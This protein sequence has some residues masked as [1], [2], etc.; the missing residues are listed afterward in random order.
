[1]RKEYTK[2][3]K[4]TPQISVEIEKLAESGMSAKEVSVRLNLDYLSTRTAFAILGIP[5]KCG[6]H[7]GSSYLPTEA[8]LLKKIESL[9]KRIE[10]LHLYYSGK[11]FDEIGKLYGTSRQYIQQ[12][13]KSGKES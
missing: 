4:I 7:G 10:M 6:R 13:L 5:L 11:T 9:Q 2:R 1:M 8:T 12:F 3:N